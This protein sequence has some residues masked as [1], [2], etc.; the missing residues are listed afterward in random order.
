MANTV[1][2]CRTT[3][4]PLFLASFP[5]PVIFTS[6]VHLHFRLHGFSLALVAIFLR[7]G[8]V[9]GYINVYTPP[10]CPTTCTRTYLHI[11]THIYTPST[12]DLSILLFYTIATS[13]S[14]PRQRWSIVIEKKVGALIYRVLSYF[15]KSYISD[16][17]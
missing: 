3:R 2:E 5:L 17:T 6:S 16:V 9:S 10:F 7:H 15:G 14:V 1:K 4:Y 12:L 11:H 13:S 8:D